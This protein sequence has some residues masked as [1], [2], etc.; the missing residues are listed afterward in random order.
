MLDRGKINERKQVNIYYSE[1]PPFSSGYAVDQYTLCELNE[2]V[3]RN[4]HV[5]VGFHPEQLAGRDGQG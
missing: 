5:F 1:E 4:Y 2:T 3:M